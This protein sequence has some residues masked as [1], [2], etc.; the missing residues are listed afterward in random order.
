MSAVPD[1][2]N[3]NFILHLKLYHFSASL[4]IRPLPDN[5]PDDM[6]KEAIIAI[7][8]GLFL[9]LVFTIGIYTANQAV[10][11]KKT[12][13]TLETTQTSPSPSPTIGLQL[14]QPENNIVVNQPNVK[15]SGHSSSEAVIAAYSEDKEIFSQAD[16][17]GDFSFDFP[18]SAGSNKITI[19][20]INGEENQQ[21][22]HIT[23]V[24]TTKL[25]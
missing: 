21:A 1:R 7:I 6:R 24:Y 4:T 10:K 12:E 9:G 22:A 2:N 25:K 19:I 3:L 13:Q 16:E 11:D 17:D 18:L 5:I 8:L 15:I 14:T 23:I 20:S